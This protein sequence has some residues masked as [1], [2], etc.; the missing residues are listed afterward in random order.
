VYWRLFSLV[1]A[2]ILWL[3][4]AGN[5]DLVGTERVVDLNVEVRNLPRDLALLERPEP[6]KVRIRGLAPLLNRQEDSL[7]AAI[8]LKDAAPGAET[9]FVS[10]EA[11]AGVDIVSVTPRWVSVYTEMIE[12]K[13]FPVSVALL[14]LDHGGGLRGFKTNPQVVTVTGPGSILNKVDRVAVYISNGRLLGLEESFPVQALDAAGR[15]L[16]LVQIEPSEVNVR[17][18]GRETENE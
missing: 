11:P 10:I 15:A 8:D 2:V 3:L 9:H 14:G 13:V 18:E 6:V 16:A 7:T 1:L 17:G 12:S 4:A 5:G